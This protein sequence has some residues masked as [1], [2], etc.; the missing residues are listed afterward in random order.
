MTSDRSTFLWSDGVLQEDFGDQIVIGDASNSRWLILRGTA[1]DTWRLLDEPRS[2]A[3]LLA[4]L[5][6]RYE[7]EP[8]RIAADVRSLLDML[9]ERG[10]VQRV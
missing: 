6:Q 9:L 5:T 10:L 7:G 2:L 8:E 1:I 4:L 3:D